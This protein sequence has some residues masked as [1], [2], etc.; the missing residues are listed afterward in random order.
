L[1]SGVIVDALLGTG[2]GGDVRG[3]YLSA[4][5]LINRSELPVMAV[6]IP[7][8]LCADTG[9][10]LGDA[11]QADVTVTLIG[12]KRGLLTAQAPDYTGA[13]VFNDLQVPAAVY[14]Q[15]P[16][17]VH[18]LELPTCLAWLQP[19]R[20]TAHKGDFGRLLVVGGDLGMAGALVMAAEA[21]ARSGA[22]LVR[23]ATHPEHITAMVARC[24]EVMA[25][26][27]SNGQQLSEPLGATDVVVIGP[28]LGKSPWSEQMLHQVRQAGLPTLLDADALNLLAA[29]DVVATQCDSNWVLTPHPAEAARLLGISVAQVQADRFSAVQEISR[30]YGGVTLL[31]GAGTLICDGNST[32]LC[33]CGNPGMASGGMGDVLSGII[34]GLMAQ[35]L[36]GMR[37]ASLG[38]VLHAVAAD[39]AAGDGQRSVLATDLL[40]PLRKL[41]G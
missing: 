35:G 33:D 40:P 1:S 22:G 18:R 6:D 17:T 20:Q 23:A 15:V 38:A 27:V 4:I 29:G 21:A 2:L 8:G 34:G 36:S 25:L 39:R 10:V 28:G 12:L 24:P 41:L 7:S 11:V 9:V 3:P 30:R 5:E 32:L 14:Q 37:A 16:A 13:V 26:P 31:K 19:R